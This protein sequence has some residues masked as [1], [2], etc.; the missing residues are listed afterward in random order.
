MTM[1]RPKTFFDFGCIKTTALPVQT[2]GVN[3]TG[4]HADVF[5]E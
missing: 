2:R 4:I 3:F 1:Q 5:V